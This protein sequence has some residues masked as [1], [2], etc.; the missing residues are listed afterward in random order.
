MSFAKSMDRINPSIEMRSMPGTPAAIAPLVTIP[1]ASCAVVATRAGGTRPE[2][3]D[4]AAAIMVAESEKPRRSSRCR[5]RSRPHN[6][7]LA[8]V[9]SGTPSSRAASWCD[10]PSRSQ[11][12]IG[13]PEDLG[14]LANLDVEHGKEWI[15]QVAVGASY[16]RNSQ[17]LASSSRRVALA[18]TSLADRTATPWSQF[19]SNGRRAIERALRASTR[20]V[21]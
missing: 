11:R 2:S 18:F 3:R 5:K 16:S 21:T 6:N 12:T 20:N 17:Y 19:A 1:S 7:R 10:L 15:D 8:I 4:K 9:P 14:Q 13:A